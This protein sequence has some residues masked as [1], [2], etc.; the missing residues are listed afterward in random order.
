MRRHA[1]LDLTLTNEEELICDV[2]ADGRLGC[3]DYE[4]F[5]FRIFRGGSRSISRVTTRDFRREDPG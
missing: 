5:E 1:L 2:K 4:M 3:D